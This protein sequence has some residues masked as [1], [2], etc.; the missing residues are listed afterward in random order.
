MNFTKAESYVFFLLADR[1]RVRSGV[2]INSTLKGD[3]SEK[4]VCRAMTSLF[5]R[6][7]IN[8]RLERTDRVIWFLTG[9][10]E[11]VHEDYVLRKIEK[12]NRSAR[13]A[14]LDWIEAALESA[15]ASMDS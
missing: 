14:D 13:G 7:Y 3:L 5:K 6:G 1:R 2:L 8:K 10:G 15:A 4:A 11:L 12:E 9:L